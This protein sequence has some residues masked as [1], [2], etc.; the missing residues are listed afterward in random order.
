MRLDKT[1]CIGV[2]LIAT[3]LVASASR[4]MT[5]KERNA[6]LIS[7]LTLDTVAYTKTPD[8]GLWPVVRGEAV[9]PAIA[10]LREGEF[11][12][13]LVDLRL[14]DGDGLEVLR[15]TQQEKPSVQVIMLTIYDYDEY[16]EAAKAAGSV[17]YILKKS[18]NGDLI[19]LIR[20]VF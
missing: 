8:G 15:F 10:T 6:L 16:R 13:A 17:G 11:D 9:Q 20:A 4:K 12:V 2:V 14:P 18:M 19:P 5:K 7:Q 1:V 3:F